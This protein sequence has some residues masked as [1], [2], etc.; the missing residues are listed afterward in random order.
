M[1]FYLRKKPKYGEHV[2]DP[3]GVANVLNTD[4]AGGSTLGG[5]EDITQHLTNEIHIH[6]ELLCEGG[7][8]EEG[9]T[10][11]GGGGEM[12]EG[13]DDTVP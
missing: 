9:N 2:S 3:A 12:G 11:K 6:H 1:Q 5:G 13:S 10:G 4:S 8:R 7:E